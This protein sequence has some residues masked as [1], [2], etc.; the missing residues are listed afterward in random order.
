MQQKINNKKK[1]T[2]VPYNSKPQR[3]LS[4]V[5]VKNM[6]IQSQVMTT[7]AFGIINV[8]TNQQ[9]DQCSQFP[10]GSWASYAAR[11]GQYRVREMAIHCKPTLKTNSCIG[12]APYNLLSVMYFSE[13]Q[14]TNIP[15]SAGVICADSKFKQFSTGSSFTYKA[16]WDRNPNAKLWSPTNAAIPVDRRYGIAYCSHTNVNLLP[17][18]TILYCFTMEFIVE[19]ADPQ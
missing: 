7:S 18:N 14:S 5:I 12:V 8:T 16:N 15:T 13:F 4:D 19:F 10:S 1:R 2:V 9:S 17:V 11:Y 3:G 6:I